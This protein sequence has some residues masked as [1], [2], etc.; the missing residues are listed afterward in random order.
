M[1]GSHLLGWVTSQCPNLICMNRKSSFLLL[2]LPL[3]AVLLILLLRKVDFDELIVCP[4]WQINKGCFVRA[5]NFVRGGKKGM[6]CFVLLRMFCTAPCKHLLFDATWTG[7]LDMICLHN[8]L[9]GEIEHDLTQFAVFRLCNES[10]GCGEMGDCLPNE[11][12]QW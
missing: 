8:F 10:T 3:F 12:T 2:I 9:G 1:E 6:G 7:L 11:Q 4:M 5:G